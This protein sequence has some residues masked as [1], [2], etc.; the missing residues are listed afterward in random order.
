MKKL[1]TPFLMAIVLLLSIS[2]N[3]QTNRTNTKKS[4]AYRANYQRM[5]SGSEAYQT[6][7]IREGALWAWGHNNKGELGDGTLNNQHSPE[8]IGTDTKWLSITS[9]FQHTVG[10]KADGSL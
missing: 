5:A 4:V 8:Q 3:A 10:L 2:S 1:F 9:G 6:F 7:E